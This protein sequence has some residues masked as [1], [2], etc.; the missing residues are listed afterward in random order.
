VATVVTSRQDGN[1]TFFPLDRQGLAPTCQ[2]TDSAVANSTAPCAQAHIPPAY[3]NGDTNWLLEPGGAYHNFSFT[4]EARFW[5]YYDS[6]RTYQLDFQGDDDVWVFVNRTLALDLGGIHTPV[7]GS[8]QLPRDAATLGLTSGNV[9]DI[10]VFQ[11]ERQT[12]GSTYKLT[13]T[14]FNLAPSVCTK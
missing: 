4:T 9:Y 10:A 3:M 8:V 7:S 1:P 14:G 13:L 2:G 5:F 11:A 12:T 6:A